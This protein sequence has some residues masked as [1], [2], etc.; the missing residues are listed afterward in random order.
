MASEIAARRLASQRLVGPKATEPAAVVRRSGAV[1]SQDY[2]A[3][4]WAVGQRVESAND[5]DLDAAFNQGAILRTHMLRPT[6]HFVAPADV[7]WI[8]ALTAPRVHAANAFMYRQQ[9]LDEQL[10]RRT[11]QLLAGWLSGGVFLTRKEVAERLGDAGIPAAGVRLAYIL[12]HA[13][14]EAVIGSGPLRGRQHTYA[15]LEERAPDARRLPREDALAELALRYFP[16]HGPAQLQDFAW[17][18]GLTMAEV[19]EAVDLAGSRLDRENFEGKTY[20]SA[21]TAADPVTS[22]PSA[23][24]LPNYDEYFIALRDRSAFFNPA[25]LRAE[26]APNGVLDRHLVLAGGDI[27]GGWRSEREGRFVT[28]GTTLLA[29]LDE[30]EREA[31]A[32]AVERYGRF[33]GLESRSLPARPPAA[34]R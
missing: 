22:E 27:V 20:W 19:R 15:L 10:L 21:P 4:K 9:E 28:V 16:S 3:A 8:Q 17:W 11:D 30:S 23:H 33:L 6:W 13:E 1:Q 24:L 32:V 14:L 26:A 12:M 7:R 29:T 31:L 34:K 2:P 5:A 25:R 18:S